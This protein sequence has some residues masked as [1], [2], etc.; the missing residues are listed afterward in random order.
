MQGTL[1]VWLVHQWLPRS[2]FKRFSAASLDLQGDRIGSV[3][4]GTV[5]AAVVVLNDYFV[6]LPGN[7]FDLV[8]RL[9]ELIWGTG[10][11]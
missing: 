4:G 8:Q 7:P 6:C 11:E 9:E 10:S 3:S 5:V 1:N 2:A